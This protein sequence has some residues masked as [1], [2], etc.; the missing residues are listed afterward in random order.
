MTLTSPATEGRAA[1]WVL[2][3]GVSVALHVGKL[4]P[5][6]PLLRDQL[7]VSL[8]QAGFLLSLVQLAG[9]SLGLAAGLLADGWGLRRT[10]LAGLCV[11]GGASVAGAFAE[12][13]AALMVLRACE[14]AGLLMAVMPAP[15]LIRRNVPPRRLAVMLGWW[16]TYMPTGSALALLAGP[17]FIALAGWAAWWLLLAAC[18][19]AMAAVVWRRVPADPVMT[20]TASTT[21]A[22]SAGTAGA[23]IGRLRATLS[24]RGPWLAA[25]S[26]AVYSGQWLAVIGFLPSIHAQAGLS[27]ALSGLLSA[28][29]AAVNMLGNVMSGRLLMAGWTPVRSLG[30]GFAAMALGSVMAFAPLG[31]DAGLRFAGVLL[32][33][34]V[35]GLIP[36]T[37]FALSV[38]LAPSGQTVST[39]VG[40]MQQLSALG[41]FAGPPLVAAAASMVG[42][43]QQTWVL[44]GA[45][46]VAGGLLAW[47]IARTLEAPAPRVRRP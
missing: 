31:Q 19:L 8:V 38:R 21:A 27:V 5:A 45:C 39:T 41:Q 24:S 35:G 13:A 3:A 46:S 2:L 40:L 28:L 14:G 44:T 47:M 17:S 16:G 30:T 9:M 4:P 29:A 43:W 18:T 26:F 37:L 33:S 25:L 11:L 20:A 22:P 23:W 42:G 6:I 1:V 10:L 36:G 34:S 7:G 32:F 12:S 15:G